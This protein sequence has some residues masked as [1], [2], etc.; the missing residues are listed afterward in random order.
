MAI[1]KTGMKRPNKS[2]LFDNID[3]S[4][5]NHKISSAMELMQ[6]LSINSFPVDLKIILQNYNIE[7]ENTSFDNDDISGMLIKNNEKYKVVVN[8]NHSQTRKNFTI[9]HELGHYFLHKDLKDKFEDRIFFRGAV[10]DNLEF[11]ANI[12]AGELLM[13]EAEFKK[14]IQSG[15]N[16][17]EEL[18][19]YFDVS[20]LAL[21]VRAKQLNLSGHGL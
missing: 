10:S 9:A 3:L 15:I 18:A 11:Q 19:A 8:Q 13:P 5:S 4:I 7:L 16:T 20:T 14:Q 21:R 6:K 17:I 12:F 2:N 1:I